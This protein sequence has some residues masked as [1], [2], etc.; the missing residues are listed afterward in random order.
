MS[1]PLV[2]IVIVNWNGL[3]HLPT[4]LKSVMKA[5]YPNSHII[6]VDNGSSDGSVEFVKISFPEV[7]VVRNPANLG[8][9]GGYNAGIAVSKGKYVAILN[10]DVE[11]DPNWLTECVRIMEKDDRVWV[12]DSKYLNYFERKVLDSVAGAGRFIDRFGNV[13][14]RGVNEV[15]KGQYDRVTEIFAGLAVFRRKAFDEIGLFDE[16]FFYGYDEIDLCWRIRSK[17]Y[18]IL[19]VP[20][21]RIYHKVSQA[22]KKGKMLKSGFYFHTKKNRLQML[23]KNHSLNVIFAVMPVV[24][25]EYSAHMAYWVIKGNKRYFL[26]IVRAILWV[27]TNFRGV[28]AKHVLIQGTK[29]AGEGDKTKGIVPY[30]GDLRLA[31]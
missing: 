12:C 9:V 13:Y 30:C 10:N 26:E 8:A 27:L 6:M 23:I 15:D 18:R 21:S 2:S 1:C 14:A 16:S 28:W 5:N 25:F 31:I 22:T 7:E 20:R 19:Y 11:V 17:G 3:A 4:C 24:L 29:N